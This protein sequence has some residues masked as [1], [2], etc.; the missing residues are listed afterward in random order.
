MERIYHIEPIYKSFVWGGRELIEYFHI[1]TALE[2]IGT[3]YAVIAIPGE[4]DNIV[5]ETK[6]PLSVFYK[7]NPQIFHCTEYF[8][9]VRM[10]VTSNSKF[11]SYQ[12]H[13]DDAYAWKAEKKKGKVSGAVNLKASDHVS[14]WLFGNKAKSLDEFKRL[15]E[16]KDWNNLF[17]RIKVK[18]G[19][20]VHTPAGVIHGGYGNGGI[21]ATFGTNGDITYRFYDNDRNDPARPLHLQQVYDCV[22]IPE[23]PVGALSVEPVEENGL[24]VYHY[25]E[26]E[27]E[28]VAKRIL[29]DGSG[30]FSY[31]GFLFVTCV[32]G[33]GTV[34]G[35]GIALGETLLIP[36]GFGEIYFEGNMNLIA[37]SYLGGQQ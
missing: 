18:D 2:N 28:Y 31:P 4:L 27:N 30:T 36:C 7:K 11:Q 6:E 34:G 17:S 12:L 3:M 26:K 9:P 23:V 14:E 13:P 19:D 22:N 20:F 1:K 10:T 37:L 35:V 15:V 24:L 8:F 21:N 29:V 33:A 32:K 25:Y 16:T 5:T